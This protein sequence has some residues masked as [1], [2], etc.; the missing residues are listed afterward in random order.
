MDLEHIMLSK[1]SQ[2]EKDKYI[3]MSHIW[4][5]KEKQTD[6]WTYIQN[7]NRLMDI[8][9]KLVVTRGESEAEEDKLGVWD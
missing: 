6:E 9:N 1:I 2:T 7:R 4:T 3:M 5:Q 8:E